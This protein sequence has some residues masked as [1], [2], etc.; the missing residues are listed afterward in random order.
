MQ[1]VQ[2]DSYTLTLLG[3]PIYVL[4]IIFWHLELSKTA[5]QENKTNI[6]G[7]FKLVFILKKASFWYIRTS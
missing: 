6:Y 4:F 3:R 5:D 1:F 2:V 7:C